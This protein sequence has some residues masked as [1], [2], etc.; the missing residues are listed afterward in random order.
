MSRPVPGMAEAQRRVYAAALRRQS[1]M[2][3]HIRESIQALGATE[4]AA[5]LNAAEAVRTQLRALAR[6][7]EHHGQV[8]LF[9][10]VARG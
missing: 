9:G 3:A 10:E 2:L 7:L 4:H 6:D 1:D 5:Y 8:D